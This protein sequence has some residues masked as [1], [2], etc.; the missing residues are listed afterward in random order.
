MLP[1]EFWEKANLQRKKLNSQKS[2]II[3]KNLTSNSFNSFILELWSITY[4]LEKRLFAPDMF[5]GHRVKCVRMRS[6]SGLYFSAIGPNAENLCI[7]KPFT[8]WV[9]ES[10]FFRQSKKQCS[11]L[12]SVWAF[13]AFLEER[14]LNKYC[15]W[16][17]NFF[18]FMQIF[19]LMW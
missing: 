14:R 10:F 15:L 18:F 7:Q 17:A 6:F 3:Y 8:Q 16:K 2:K 9:C 19:G 11:K 4:A 13:L 1:E 5:K 12:W